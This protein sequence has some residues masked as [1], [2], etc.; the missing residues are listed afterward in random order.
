[1]GIGLAWAIAILGN[2]LG[3]AIIG[4]LYSYAARGSWIAALLPLPYL[5]IILLAI[6]LYRKGKP[7]TGLGLMLGLLSMIAVAL[8]LVAACFGMMHGGIGE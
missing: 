8:L 1:M 5:L 7:R 4:S 6:Y 3:A 2:L